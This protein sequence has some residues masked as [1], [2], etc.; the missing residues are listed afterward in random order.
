MAIEV[1]SQ[2]SLANA[3]R[4]ANRNKQD[5]TIIHLANDI[6]LNANLPKI[7]ADIAFEGNGRT[8][9]GDDSYHIFDV[10]E[11]KLTI[12][13]LTLIKGNAEFGGAIHN[14][15]GTLVIIDSIISGNSAK[16]GG[17]ICNLIGT[18]TI[19]NCIISGNSAEA[20][21]VIFSGNGTLTIINS[22]LSHNSAKHGGAILTGGN[23]KLTVTDC[24][25]NNNSA[26]AGGAIASVAVN[27]L[28]RLFMTLKQ[29]GKIRASKR[30][31]GALTITNSTFNS[32]LAE[33]V[34]GAVF[35]VM[36]TVTIS[37][38]T[39]RGNSSDGDGGA[40]GVDHYGTV[41]I[42]NN[43][44]SNN[45]SK[46]YG[47][48]IGSNGTV[49]L[50]NSTFRGNSSDA[51]GG[52]IACYKMITLADS[53]FSNNSAAKWGGAIVCRN[54][55][56][57]K[58]SRSTFKNNSAGHGSGAI[59]STGTIIIND[60]AFVNNSAGYEGGALDNGGALT[61]NN[62]TISGNSAEQRGGGVYVDKDSKTSLTHV[63][64]VNNSAKHGGGIY[65]H[66]G[67]INLY[68]SIITGSRGG[69]CVGKLNQ[70]IGNLIEDGSGN[71]ELRGNPA[72]GAFIEPEDDS[73]AYY[74]LLDKSPA[75]D[76]AHP[77]YCL[78][79]DQ[80][81]IERPQGTTGDI[82]AIELPQKQKR[83][84]D[85]LLDGR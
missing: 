34:G 64:L 4:F 1:N 85:L 62:S 61:I 51:S 65:K 60:S 50:V 10:V 29:W 31:K 81:G 49:T 39:F 80:V 63:T 36:G 42:T 68:N 16:N 45:S 12:N 18:L 33:G 52:A 26:G 3:I 30:D 57:L 20:G 25:F 78:P 66:S 76:A 9:S 73:P 82:G 22:E 72:L 13:Q 54:D 24:T 38:S 46:A 2:E 27:S 58:I 35:I 74:L 14:F 44:F 70:N 6:T 84:I 17:A 23:E 5:N 69:D 37:N 21:G 59:G 8:I 53:I 47:G 41:I 75:I 83:L 15:M 77:D 43:T 19:I 11:S 79:T 28:L 67:T 55:T 40:I 7:T 32:N 48:A 56:L 71:P